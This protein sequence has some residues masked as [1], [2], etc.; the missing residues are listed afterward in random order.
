MIQS[1]AFFAYPVADM[2]RARDFYERVLGLK[3]DS[4]FND[5]WVEYDV[6]GATFAITTM[7]AKHR[8]GPGAVLAVEV[9]DLA[10]A[11]A[12]MKAAGVRL[13]QENVESPV[14]RFSVVLD[15]DGNEVILH[16]RKT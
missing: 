15:P 13:V 1:I 6:A 11:S 7:D 4:S 14:C 2:K 9:E 12:R 16:K 10:A 5:E 3:L 8:P